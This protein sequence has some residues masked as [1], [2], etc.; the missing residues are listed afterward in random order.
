MRLVC[1]PGWLYFIIYYFE[2]EQFQGNLWKVV[3]STGSAARVVIALEKQF[4]HIF[5]CKIDTAQYSVDINWI[6]VVAFYPYVTKES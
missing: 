4:T 3:V 1:K 5:I 6:L 2:T